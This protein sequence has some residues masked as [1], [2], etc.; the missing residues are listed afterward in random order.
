MLKYELYLNDILRTIEDI[1][2]SFDSKTREYFEKDCDIVEATA[3]RLQIIGESIKNLP[4]KVKKKHGEINWDDFVKFR[5]TISHVYF[6]VDKDMLWDSV[7]N[8][9][10]KLKKI[11]RKIK[12]E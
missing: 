6:K 5:N 4:D 7:K 2:K 1:E 11:V 9:I 10:P 8:D 3:M 12:N